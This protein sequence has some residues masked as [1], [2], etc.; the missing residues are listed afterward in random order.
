[1]TNS[2]KSLFVIFAVASISRAQQPSGRATAEFEVASV[3]SSTPATG[4]LGGVFTYP[5]G[6]V[7]FRGCTLQYLIEQAFDIQTFQVSGGPGWMQDQRYD[8][9]AK[10]PASSKSGKSMPGNAKTPPNEEQR[11][12]LQSLLVE[13]FGLKYHREIREGPVYL[14]LKGNKALKL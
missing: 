9:D 12:M 2:E 13:R 10:P 4:V 7:A 14:L 5:G 1:M 8:I 11:Q 3:K 6:R